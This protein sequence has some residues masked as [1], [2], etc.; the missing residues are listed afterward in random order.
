M[1]HLRF[2]VS[3]G[4]LLIALSACSDL[5]CRQGEVR[6]A[7]TCFTAR[8]KPD[9]GPSYAESSGDA[10]GMLASTEADGSVYT[11][12]SSDPAKH[13]AT[14]GTI[15]PPSGPGTPVTY[16]AGI[17]PLSDAT[18][19]SPKQDAAVVVSPVPIPAPDAGPPAPVVS[20]PVALGLGAVCASKDV[21]QSGH[22]VTGICCQEQCG[23]CQRCSPTGACENI[24]A[25]GSGDVPGAC[26]ELKSCVDNVCVTAETNTPVSSRSYVYGGDPAGPKPDLV[27]QNIVIGKTGF[28]TA[29]RIFSDCGESDNAV[30]LAVTKVDSNDQP[31]A[32]ELGRATRYAAPVPVYVYQSYPGMTEFRFPRLA[33]TSGAH[34]GLVL[35]A[36]NA[37]RYCTVTAAGFNSYAAGRTLTRTNGV[38]AEDTSVGDVVFQVL[39]GD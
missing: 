25:N 10:G 20:T 24:F 9:A 23:S 30:T 11:D 39:I 15:T 32:P 19:T 8:S 6:V 34:L 14:T 33:V 38:F 36:V 13:T 2:T 16:D 31:V 5:E 3:L 18:A 1:R 37:A 35:S 27:V 17:P 22:C 4:T 12:A 26:A 29:V 7:D 21:C 28:L